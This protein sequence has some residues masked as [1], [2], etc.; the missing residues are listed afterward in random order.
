[1]GPRQTATGRA[2]DAGSPANARAVGSKDRCTARLPTA[3]NGRCRGSSAGV[4]VRPTRY[5]SSSPDAL[6]LRQYA[7]AARCPALGLPRSSLLR[8]ARRRAHGQGAQH[9]N[10]SVFATRRRGQVQ[11]RRPNAEA[12]ATDRTEAPAADRT[13]APAADRAAHASCRSWK[14]T[15][16]PR[17]GSPQSRPS[18]RSRSEG[19]DLHWAMLSRWLACG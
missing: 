13:E 4:V 2:S 15:Q 16:H 3:G 11:P 7:E 6:S 17:P 18:G 10:A 5:R 1:M 19:R 12:P 14:G 9:P 8:S